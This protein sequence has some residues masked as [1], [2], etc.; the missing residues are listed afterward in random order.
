MKNRNIHATAAICKP[1]V[2]YLF[3]NPESP[4]ELFQQYQW[5]GFTPDQL[6]QYVGRLSL[7]ISIFKSSPDDSNVKLRLRTDALNSS[8]N[9]KKKV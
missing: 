3:F 2:S 5:T 6:N 9:T 7:G 4:G 1:L 8:K